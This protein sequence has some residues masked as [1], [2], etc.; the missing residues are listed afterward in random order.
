MKTKIMYALFLL[1]LATLV[2]L[3][4]TQAEG[5]HGGIVKK[6]EGYYIEM[7]NN[8]D[9]SFFAYLLSK[10]QKTISNQNI[11]GEVQLF[12]PDSTTLDVKLTPIAGNGFTAKVLTGFYACKITF[13]VFEKEVSAQFEKQSQIVQRKDNPINTVK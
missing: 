9:T 6:A 3:G 13:H 7:K 11:S 12:F 10:K 1:A 4:S 5:P 8:P 2:S